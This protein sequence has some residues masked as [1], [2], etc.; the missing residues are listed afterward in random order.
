MAPRGTTRSRWTLLLGAGLA[1]VA[2]VSLLTFATLA[3]RTSLQDAPGPRVAAIEGNSAPQ[4]INLPTPTPTG[5]GAPPAAAT[6]EFVAFVPPVG[7]PN[8]DGTATP[9]ATSVR[10]DPQGPAKRSD[11]E[12][13]GRSKENNTEPEPQ[14]EGPGRSFA[15]NK[16]DD[17]PGKGP[18]HKPSKPSK[19]SKS[20]SKVDEA[21]GHGSSQGRGHAKGR[22]K[23]HAKHGD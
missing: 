11:T 23:G 21:H 15:S 12:G 22:G 4:E 3:R 14:D 17:K 18:S 6:D 2:I 20:K 19:P 16:N 5:N 13:K 7:A 10:N 9:T 1:A 8:V